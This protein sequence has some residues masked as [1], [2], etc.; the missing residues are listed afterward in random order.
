M[1]LA[2]LIG[3]C[4]CKQLPT[5]NLN[6]T[7]P[8]AQAQ[9]HHTYSTHSQCQACQ[10]RT[11][12]TA[13]AGK[14]SPDSLSNCSN[15]PT[16]AAHLQWSAVTAGVSTWLEAA[17][18]ILVADLKQILQVRLQLIRWHLCPGQCWLAT[19]A[20]TVIR[21]SCRD[22]YQLL[23][24]FCCHLLP[25][26]LLPWPAHQGRLHNN[27]ALRGALSGFLSVY[28]RGFFPRPPGESCC[29]GET[30][31]VSESFHAVGHLAAASPF[32]ATGEAG[33]V[34]ADR[35]PRWRECAVARCGL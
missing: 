21:Q 15:S 27:K 19:C 25:L 11:C 31:G 7:T 24:L 35:W 13:S 22:A 14:P 30:G 12:V 1:Q 29:C 32:H 33:G 20:A 34:S 9:S 28:S 2:I 3:I 23:P 18:A 4:L 17:V 26:S 16:A 5:T 6:H 8:R 10:I